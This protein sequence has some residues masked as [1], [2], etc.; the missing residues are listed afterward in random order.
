MPLSLVPFHLWWASFPGAPG[1]LLS[2]G[3]Q[4][5]ARPLKRR[6]RA[7]QCCTPGA[8]ITGYMDQVQLVLWI[9]EEVLLWSHH[10]TTVQEHSYKERWK[11]LQFQTAGQEQTQS[12]WKLLRLCAWR[13]AHIDPC[14]GQG[15]VK[16]PEKAVTDSLSA[17]GQVLPLAHRRVSGSTAEPVSE[18]F[19]ARAEG[20]N[21]SIHK[22]QSQR[23]FVSSRIATGL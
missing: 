15:Q 20:C 6:L 22:L 17:S 9:H 7:V 12:R 18:I 16:S 23:A 2:L 1:H 10:K 13:C 4:A 19:K 11:L 5:E 14:L 21:S 8:M 3:A